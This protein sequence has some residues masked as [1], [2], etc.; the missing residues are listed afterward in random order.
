[1]QVS[2]FSAR[3]PVAFDG[4]FREIERRPL[5][6]GAWVDYAP[7]SLAV[8]DRL[9]EELEAHVAWRRTTQT[10]YDRKVETPRRVAIFSDD[11]ATPEVVRAM[12]EALS[13]RYHVKLERLSAA[14]YR[15]GQD[16]VAW[17]RD[18]EHRERA[19]AIVAIVC[20]GGPRRF[21]LRPHRPPADGPS[22]RRSI[23]YRLGSR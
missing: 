22:L 2:L 18:R 3:S 13:A 7:G 8:H 23:E 14:L 6:G 5:I 20:V 15:D 16:S 9:F 17:H 21:L 4:R 10:I 1:M 11:G 19:E 12:A